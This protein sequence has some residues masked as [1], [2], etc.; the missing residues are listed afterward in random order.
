[1]CKE[2]ANI[3]FSGRLKCSRT[4][5]VECKDTIFSI[6]AN[7]PWQLVQPTVAVGATNHGSC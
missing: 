2:G 6:T 1:M 5:L 3:L 7:Q 4:L